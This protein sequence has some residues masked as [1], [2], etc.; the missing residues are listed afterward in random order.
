MKTIEALLAEHRFFKD[1]PANYLSILKGCG[2]NVQWESGDI[3]FK[4]GNP[5]N[6]FYALREGSIA[7]EIHTPNKGTLTLQTLHAGDVLGWSWLFPPY[8]WHF[9]ARA[10]EPTRAT[11]LDGKCLREK[12]DKDP[13]FGYFMM[14]HFANLLLQR[15]QTTRV[16]LLE[17]YCESP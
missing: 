8:E 5:A 12:C 15:L 9:D 6:E 2:K 3:L 4:E 7:L 10:L 1:F 11:A 16:A 17:S 14:K 13:A